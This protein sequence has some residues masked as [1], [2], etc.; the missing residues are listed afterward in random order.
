MAQEVSTGP[1]SGPRE[2]WKTKLV[3]TSVGGGS[4]TRRENDF[5]YAVTNALPLGP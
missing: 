5:S 3:S 4:P 1:V 2:K